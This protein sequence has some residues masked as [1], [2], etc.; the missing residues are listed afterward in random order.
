M[1]KCPFFGKCG[2]CKFDFTADDYRE[3]KLELLKNIPITDDP[4]WLSDG[5]RRRADFA[6]CDKKFGFYIPCSKNIVSIDYCSL[7]VDEI[8]NILPEISQLPF[9]GSGSVLITSCE[10][11]IDIA[12]NSIVP[13]FTSDFKKEAEKIGAIRITWNDRIVV[14][15]DDPIIKFGEKVIRYP[16]NSF[17]QPSADG[18]DVLRGLVNK[19][20]I[21]SKKVVDLFC[22]LGSFTFAL[23]AVGYDIAGL[24]SSR[25]LL[26]K[27]LKANE[28]N[29][30]DCA[31]IDPPRGGAA[32]QLKE[33]AKSNLEK[34]IYVSCNPNTFMRDADVLKKN[35][36][37]L[38]D[39]SPVDQ[40]VGSANWELV[41]FFRRN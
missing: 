33:I 32:A 38:S 11:G 13:Y 14:Q 17:L 41:G 36:F 25:D 10:N 23:H 12:I 5:S 31:V 37:I 20:A 22:G 2:G 3:K 15:T 8:N 9:V 34:V 21:G 40:F 24:G 18:E 6:F 28:L 1:K 35:G 4:I 29:K 39:L 30:Y 27:P 7:L 26:K 19:Y 16:S